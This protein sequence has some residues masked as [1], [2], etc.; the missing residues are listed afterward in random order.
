MK[1]DRTKI[2]IVSF[3]VVANRSA[4]ISINILQPILSFDDNQCNLWFVPVQKQ[5][6]EHDDSFNLQKCAVK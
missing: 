6:S 3:P 2:G 1:N 5:D 4:Y